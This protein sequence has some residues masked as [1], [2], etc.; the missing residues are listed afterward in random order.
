MK[1]EA[2]E[3][4]NVG[5]INEVILGDKLST[6]TDDGVVQSLAQLSVLD[7]D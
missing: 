6:P 3:L 7:V 1:Y 4:L 5:A 2:P